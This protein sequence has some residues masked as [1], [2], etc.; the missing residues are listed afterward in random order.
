MSAY[1]WDG[2]FVLAII[3]LFSACALLVRGCERI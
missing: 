3:L 1:L 2:G